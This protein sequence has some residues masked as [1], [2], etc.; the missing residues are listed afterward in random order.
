MYALFYFN[1][2]I[3]ILCLFSVRLFIFL[4]V[5]CSCSLFNPDIN[6]INIVN[7]FS[8]LYYLPFHCSCYLFSPCLDLLYLMRPIYQYI[9]FPHCFWVSCINYQKVSSLPRLCERS[10]CTKLLIFLM[11]LRYLYLY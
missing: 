8:P 1:K 10:G 2:L 7:L 5:I 11:L 4:L 9:I 6:V 3:H